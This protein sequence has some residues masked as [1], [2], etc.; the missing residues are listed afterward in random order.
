MIALATNVS[1]IQAVG[2]A[3]HILESF[4]LTL[5][6]IAL[7]SLGLQTKLNFGESRDPA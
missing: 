6:P 4:T 2:T 5:T 1:G 3:E 7:L